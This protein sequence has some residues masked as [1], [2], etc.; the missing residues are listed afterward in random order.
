MNLK[1]EN[2]ETIKF[3]SETFDS[4]KIAFEDDE[5]KETWTDLLPARK[6]SYCGREID[7]T[8][9]SCLQAIINFN[10]GL[11][12]GGAK[13]DLPY[14]F[15][16]EGYGK[17]SGWI[18]AL[19]FNEEK[20]MLQAKVKWSKAGKDAIEGDEYRYSSCEFTMSLYIEEDSSDGEVDY[21]DKGMAVFGAALTNRPFVKDM[22]NV[23]LSEEKNLVATDEKLGD[24]VNKQTKEKALD[25]EKEFKSLE[26]KFSDQSNIVEELQAKNDKLEEK[27]K[28]GEKTAKFNEM[29]SANKVVEGQ[30]E[31]FMN[32]NIVAFSEAAVALNFEEKGTSETVVVDVEPKEINFTEEAEKLSIEEKISFSDAMKKIVAQHGNEKGAE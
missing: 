21:I 8:K 28:L 14:D 13:K 25:Y 10:S 18:E 23:K 20:Q 12:T 5:N 31:A 22:N 17:A 24:N 26:V 2:N 3:K 11:V 30:R 6:Y 9:E 29:L 27:V 19:R 1:A 32:D 15:N 4:L 7:V 16:H